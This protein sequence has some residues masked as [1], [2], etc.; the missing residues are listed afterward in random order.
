MHELENT[1]TSLLKQRNPEPQ[2]CLLVGKQVKKTGD[3]RKSSFTTLIIESFV[4]QG[5]SRYF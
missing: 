3:L 2:V 5:S 1:G 4:L